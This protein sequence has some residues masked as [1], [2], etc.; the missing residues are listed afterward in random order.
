M[1]ESG[2]SNFEGFG[3]YNPSSKNINEK[4]KQIILNFINIL[5]KI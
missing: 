1:L 3:E 4:G 2:F 5:F